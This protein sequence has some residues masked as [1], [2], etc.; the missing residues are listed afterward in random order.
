MVAGAADIP[1]KNYRR[2]ADMLRR[3]LK[4]LGFFS[5]QRTLWFYPFDPRKELEYVVNSFGIANFVTLMEVSRLDR[6]D[7][8][9]MKKFFRVS[10]IL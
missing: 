2:G 8:E 4:E 6:D 9:I 1:T 5:L 10:K 3:K 7:E